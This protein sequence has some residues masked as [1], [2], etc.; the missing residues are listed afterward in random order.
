[1]HSWMYD[2]DIIMIICTLCQMTPRLEGSLGDNLW[3]PAL[4]SNDDDDGD[5]MPNQD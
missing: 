1:M 4:Q 5:A 3:S 2:L